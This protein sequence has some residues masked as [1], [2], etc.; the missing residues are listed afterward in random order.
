MILL[1]PKRSD[2]SVVEYVTSSAFCEQVLEVHTSTVGE[3][4]RVA[5]SDDGT[6]ASYS[7]QELVVPRK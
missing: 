6:T 1:L 3:W 2:R 7:T 4:A 5:W